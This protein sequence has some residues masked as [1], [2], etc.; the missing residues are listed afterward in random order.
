MPLV[1]WRGVVQNFILLL[2]NSMGFQT[3]ELFISGISHLIFLDSGWPRLTET[4]ISQRMDKRDSCIH[5]NLLR[6]V[7]LF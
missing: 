6:E 7:V 2:R 4:I 5:M 1:G 3:Y